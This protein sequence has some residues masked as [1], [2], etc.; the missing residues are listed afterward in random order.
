VF[1]RRD[2]AGSH[3]DAS[4]P[5]AHI[6]ASS[7]RSRLRPRTSEAGL[8]L[9]TASPRSR[10]EQAIVELALRHKAL[11]QQLATYALETT[12]PRLTPLDRAFWVA[13]SRFWP[14]WRDALVIVKPET[15]I[16]G[17][18]KGF[19]L[20]WRSIS[21]RGPGRP[22]ISHELQ[23]LIRRLADENNW[24]ARKIQAELEKLGFTIGLATV[25]RY[26]PKRA[27]DPGTQQRWM[28]FLRNHKHG[29][30]A[31]DF[32]VVPTVSF[33]LLYVW[34]VIDHGR[35]RIVHFNV[36]TNPTAQWVS[37]QLREAFPDN[38][39]PRYLIFDNDSIFSDEVSSSILTLGITPRRTAFRSPWQNGTAERWVGT[40]KR[41]LID[42]VVVL[43]EDHLRR[44][45]RDYAAYYNADRVHTRLADAP[46]GRPVEVRPSPEAKVIGLP[47]VGGLHHRYAWQQA[48]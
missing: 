29:I 45:L 38:S 34:F 31:M 23:A 42:H 20:Y 18:R 46:D 10:N 15:V 41:E 7:L 13:L 30:T 21:K 32:F 8:A 12:R 3:Q 37:Q 19:R 26:L 1:R 6:G 5:P 33:R 17:Y 9:A 43:G 11:R 36:T 16:R 2:H 14:H 4:T 47:R 48:A 22:P 25:S 27:P 35:R 44:L 40:C 28:T 24:R 39:A